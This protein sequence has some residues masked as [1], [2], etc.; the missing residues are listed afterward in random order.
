MQHQSTSFA[1]LSASNNASFNLATRETPER[2]EGEIATAN[3]FGTFGIQPLTG[4]VF[5]T[6]EDKPGHSQV[7]VISERLWRARLRRTPR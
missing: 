7:V 2:V 5:T 3:Y 4:R 6:D 1:S